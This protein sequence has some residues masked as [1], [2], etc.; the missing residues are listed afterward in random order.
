M[1]KTDDPMIASLLREREGYVAFGKTDRVKAVDEELKRRG[2]VDEES[3]PQG[4]ATREQKQTTADDKP[5]KPTAA[6]A[7]K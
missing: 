5:A 6:K 1:S 7:E 3:K 2:Y 4:R